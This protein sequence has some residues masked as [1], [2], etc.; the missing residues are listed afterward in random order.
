MPF[1]RGRCMLRF[2]LT[3]DCRATK[4]SRSLLGRCTGLMLVGVG[5]SGSCTAERQQDIAAHMY[6]L[7]AS[8]I[9]HHHLKQRPLRIKYVNTYSSAMQH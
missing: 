3:Q 7:W 5:S 2:V 6:P 1:R 4:C 8:Q 9:I